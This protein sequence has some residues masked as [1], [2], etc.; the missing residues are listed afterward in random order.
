MTTTSALTPAGLRLAM[1]DLL[2]PEARGSAPPTLDAACAALWREDPEAVQLAYDAAV[3]SQGGINFEGNGRH[4][5][6]ALAMKE[7]HRP[8]H[9]G[10]VSPG[11]TITDMADR[12]GLQRETLAALLEH[13]GYIE[14]APFGRSQS[15]RLC[16]EATIKAG[17]G[18]NTEGRQTHTGAMR[19]SSAF[20]LIHEAWVEKIIW[21]LD[22][23]GIVDAVAALP[24]KRRRLSW[25]LEQHRYL[26]DAEIAR[27]AGCTR[28]SV[29]RAR[30]K[31][32]TQVLYQGSLEGTLQ[33]GKAS[34]DTLSALA[35]AL[36]DGKAGKATYGRLVF[37]SASPA[38]AA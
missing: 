14:T 8:L 24:T 25:L 20:A 35:W 21:S 10:P 5:L 31:G 17:Y 22:W 26:P 30:A 2:H 7:Q 33:D 28:P 37:E 38:N 16:T 1:F 9:D 15:R 19:T 34:T 13:H 32:D 4:G 6:F 27:L 12:A 36:R 11:I 29:G 18:R 23:P 3:I